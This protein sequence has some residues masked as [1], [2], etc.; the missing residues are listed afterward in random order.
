MVPLLQQAAKVPV[1]LTGGHREF[2]QTNLL[3][4]EYGV[5]YF[6]PLI[7]EENL[8]DRWKMEIPDRRNMHEYLWIPLRPYSAEIQKKAEKE[9]LSILNC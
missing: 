1:I 7:R 4:N 3:L 2:E 6:R 5:D 9:P 8:P